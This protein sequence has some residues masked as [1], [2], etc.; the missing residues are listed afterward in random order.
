MQKSDKEFH[1]ETWI[2]TEN[3]N[4]KNYIKNFLIKIKRKII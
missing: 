2:V 1:K 3:T 4:M